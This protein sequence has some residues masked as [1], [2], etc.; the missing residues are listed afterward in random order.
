MIIKPGDINIDFADIRT[1]MKDS[2]NALLGIGYG[3]GE[4]RAVDAAR[5]AI[6]NPLLE[7]NLDGAK[8]VIFAVTGGHDLTPIEVQEAASIIEELCDPDVN[9][10]WGMTLDESYDD[11]V[12]VTV[13]ATGFN[14]Y[15]ENTALKRPQRDEL[16]RKMGQPSSGNFISRSMESNNAEPAA[17][18]QPEEDYDTPAFMRK[19]I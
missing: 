11:E 18:V 2:G 6:E 1:I 7:Q 19:R 9:L 3:A 16:G 12:K 14:S 10:V 15:E 13:I 4:K 5:R 17:P 8:N